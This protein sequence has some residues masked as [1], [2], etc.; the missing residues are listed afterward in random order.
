MKIDGVEY[1]LEQIQPRRTRDGV[2]FVGLVGYDADNARN[3]VKLTSTELEQIVD[4]LSRLTTI[5][6]KY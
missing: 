3:V 6:G 4:K 5:T 1:E 2:L